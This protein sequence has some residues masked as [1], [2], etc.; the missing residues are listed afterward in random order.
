M[1]VITDPSIA[2]IGGVKKP[3]IIN[4]TETKNDSTNVKRLSQNV[5][6]PSPFPSAIDTFITC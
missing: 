1:A 4:P 5:R 6:V 3:P 2:P